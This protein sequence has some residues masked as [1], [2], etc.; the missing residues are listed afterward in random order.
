[1]DI[2]KWP[3]EITDNLPAHLCDTE[4][5]IISNLLLLNL[6]SL[7]FYCLDKRCL[8]SLA[9]LLNDRPSKVIATWCTTPQEIKDADIC[10]LILSR[11]DNIISTHLCDLLC[12]RKEAGKREEV[13]LQFCEQTSIEN[14]SDLGHV[15]G[16]PF[17]NSSRNQQQLCSGFLAGR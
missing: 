12:F 11:H 7:Y 8:Q 15:S 10:W 9:I 14:S 17:P 6:D 4:D 5:L 3:H 13:P 1:M 16:I 2:F